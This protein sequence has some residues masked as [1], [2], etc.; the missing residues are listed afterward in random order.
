MTDAT[1]YPQGNCLPHLAV[2]LTGFPAVA[3]VLLLLLPQVLDLYV[4]VGMVVVLVATGIRL[5]RV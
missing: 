4:A 5:V 2:R 1:T 3:G